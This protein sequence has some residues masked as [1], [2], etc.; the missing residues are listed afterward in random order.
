MSRDS[1]RDA[2][3]MRQGEKDPLVSISA[4]KGLPYKTVS[5]VSWAFCKVRTF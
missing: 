3:A 2:L 4:D 1:L 5:E